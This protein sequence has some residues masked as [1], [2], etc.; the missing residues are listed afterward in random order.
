MTHTFFFMG[1]LNAAG[2]Q[3]KRREQ[4]SYTSS[5]QTNEWRTPRTES[6]RKSWHSLAQCGKEI[7]LEIKSWSVI[8]GCNR[9]VVEISNHHAD[10]DAYQLGLCQWTTFFRNLRSVLGLR[11]HRERAYVTW[12]GLST[13]NKMLVENHWPETPSLSVMFSRFPQRCPVRRGPRNDHP[14][15]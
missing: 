13:D 15:S 8:A 9:S 7:V 10:T 5:K 12:E 14:R 6:S 1:A 11:E 2:R 3:G 4:S